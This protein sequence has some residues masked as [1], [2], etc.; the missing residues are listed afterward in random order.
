MAEQD[1]DARRRGQ[2]TRLT[3]GILDVFGF[4]DLETN[5][6]EQLCINF[7]N[8]KLQ[9]HFTAAP[10]TP[11]RNSPLHTAQFPCSQAHF[12][13]AVFKETQMEYE[14]EGIDVA[15]IG[16]RDN[17]AQVQL[18]DGRPFGMLSLLE[19]E[20]HV[21]RGSDLGFLG[22]VDEQ[23]GKGRNAFFVR[24]KVRK[25]D[26]E[27]AFVLKHYAGEVTYHV[28]GWLEK[29]RGF[30]RADM[31]RL[32]ITSDCHL[33]TNLPGVVE[34]EPK[35]EASSGGRGRGGRGGGGGKRNTTVGTKFAA[36]LT[37]L[38][39]LLNSVSSRFI[40]CLKPNMLKRCDCFDGEAVLRQLRYTGMLECIHIRRSGFPIKVPIAQLV[41][42]MAPLFALMP[43]EERASRPPVE[44]LKLLLMVE[45]ASAKE[46]LSL[47][48]KERD[49]EPFAVGRTK[50]FMRNYVY[51]HIMAR[52][53]RLRDAASRRLQRSQ[54]RRTAIRSAARVQL[55]RMM[56]VGTVDQLRRVVAAAARVAPPKELKQAR[57]TLNELETAFGFAARLEEMEAAEDVAELGAVL[58]AAGSGSTLTRRRRRCAR[59]HG[60]GSKRR[61][62][63]WCYC[64]RRGSSSDYARRRRRRTPRQSRARCRRHASG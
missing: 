16:F 39:T 18:M 48:V 3:V 40:R 63:R 57:A 42:K 7:T 10:F 41:E 26:M 31:R 35:E 22:K 53:D 44:L 21:P 45:G 8:E 34:D 9:A 20:C 56:L 29:S 30:L 52:R 36:E 5:S 49:Y 25:A 62:G 13:A 11:A 6:F 17:D 23:H 61:S 2:K 60:D 12:T 43:A 27:D 51:A 46:A 15:S 14:E 55:R 37:Q 32:L 28:A 50:V 1:A 54:R 47:R 38:V 33:L 24:P 64:K 4:E 19:E 58:S 59:C